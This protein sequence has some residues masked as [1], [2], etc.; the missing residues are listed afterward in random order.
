MPV[1]V[2]R[3]DSVTGINE[4]S[5][6]F[7]PGRAGVKDAAVNERHRRPGAPLNRGK[8]DGIAHRATLPNYVDGRCLLA[9]GDPYP[10]T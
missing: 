8:L 5:H 10:S 9:A 7:G 2:D 1:P 6:A 3:D 4:R